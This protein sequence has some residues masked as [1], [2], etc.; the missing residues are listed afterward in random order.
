MLITGMTFPNFA[1][2]EEP[3]EDEVAFNAMKTAIEAGATLWNAGVFYGFGPNGE[4]INLELIARFFDKYP[5]LADKV[6]LAVKGGVN[7]KTHRPD[8]N[9]EFL[10][11]DVDGILKALN[12][13]KKLDLYEMARVD[14][15][16]YNLLSS[17]MALTQTN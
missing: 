15:N 6:F 3:L 16:T 12:G 7:M 8:G 10:R 2:R 17:K 11:Q 1:P 5:Q 4:L 14:K 13:K 9:P